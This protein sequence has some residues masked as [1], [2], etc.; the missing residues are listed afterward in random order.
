M[1]NKASEEYNIYFFKWTNWKGIFFY[2][3]KKNYWNKQI[4]IL[5]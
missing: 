1:E 2:H 3:S 5:N 4:K